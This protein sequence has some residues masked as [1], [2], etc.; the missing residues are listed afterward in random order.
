MEKKIAKLLFLDI[1]GV[2]TSVADGT[3]YL[4]GNPDNYTF[5]S[6][7]MYRLFGLIKAVPELKVVIHSG[8]VKWKHKPDFKWDFTRR[9]GV[10]VAFESLLFQLVEILRDDGVYLDCVDH[11]SK[12]N[13]RGDIEA[14]LENNE[15]SIAENCKIV[16]FDDDLRQELDK[17][18]FK[19]RKV[20]Y[21]YVPSF[22][23]LRTIDVEAAKEFFNEVN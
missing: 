10:V 9:D 12:R 6:S 13:K 23:G 20:K 18:A 7:A 2:L 1:D 15:K 19:N 3:S 14:W 21:L 4:C 11:V 22:S 8:W 17:V 16:I 5:S